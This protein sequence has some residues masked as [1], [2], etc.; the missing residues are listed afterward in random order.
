M[1]TNATKQQVEEAIERV[2]K[3]YGYQLDINNWSCPT[4]DTF[5]FTIKSK[6]SGIPGAKYSFSGRNLVSAS[7]RAHGYMM[8]EIFRINPKCYIKS[9]GT[10]HYKGFEWEDKNT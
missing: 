4:R 3:K 6:K 10:K 2:N 8:D 5:R 1:I 7:W 9:L